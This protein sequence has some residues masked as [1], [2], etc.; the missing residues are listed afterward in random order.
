MNHLNF[1][2]SDRKTTTASSGNSHINTKTK[3]TI[4]IKWEREHV[5]C[6]NMSSEYSILYVFKTKMLIVRRRRHNNNWIGFHSQLICVLFLSSLALNFSIGNGLDYTY[7]WVCVACVAPSFKDNFFGIHVINRRGI[8]Y[9]WIAKHN[10]VVLQSIDILVR[11]KW[12]EAKRLETKTTEKW[13][14]IEKQ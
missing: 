5:Q 13:L 1:W 12:N 6:K 4:R 3:R 9:P 11:F 14:A 8:F 7:T 2:D 10:E